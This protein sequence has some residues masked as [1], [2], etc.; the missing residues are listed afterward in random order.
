M[1]II[2]TYFGLFGSRGL[3]SQS[4]EAHLLRVFFYFVKLGGP[5][6]ECPYNESTA[7]WS[8]DWGP[9]FLEKLSLSLSL[10]LSRLYTLSLSFMI[11]ISIYINNR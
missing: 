5:F 9:S 4:I 8:L 1:P 6:C 2:H 11:Y 10:S 7:V 3:G